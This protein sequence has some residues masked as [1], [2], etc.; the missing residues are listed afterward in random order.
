[1]GISGGWIGIL[2]VVMGI[3][4]GAGWAGACW[5]SKQRFPKVAAAIGALSFF[6]AAAFVALTYSN[7]KNSE[8]A[9]YYILG[10]YVVAA[11]VG[12]GGF[13]FWF[14]GRRPWWHAAL[15]CAYDLLLL[16]AITW[17][18]H[19]W[20]HFIVQS[21]ITLYSPTAESFEN[22]MTYAFFASACFMGVVML[23]LTARQSKREN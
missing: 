10:I 7:A 22:G 1:M 23:I 11:F 13:L 12:I 6:L 18:I 9:A 15:E 3:F 8:V 5:F 17:A 20:A 14:A 16:S 2:G 4:A 19:N 21:P